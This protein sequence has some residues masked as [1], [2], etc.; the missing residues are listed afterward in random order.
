MKKCICLFGLLIPA[1]G[2]AQSYSIDWYK[3]AGGGGTEYQR[4]IQLERHRRPAG[5]QYRD[6]RRQL[7]PYRRLLEPHFRGANTRRTQPDHHAVGQQRHCLLAGHGQLHLATEQQSGCIGGL[8]HQWISSHHQLP[9]R[10]QQHH[11]HAARRKSILPSGQ[12]LKRM[13]QRSCH[14]KKIHKHLDDNWL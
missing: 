4:S 10:H 8:G 7:L 12:S 6:D 5:C 3:V 9:R 1:L 14:L 13:E 11:H 2:Q